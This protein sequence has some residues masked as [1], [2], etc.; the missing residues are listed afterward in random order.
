MCVKRELDELLDIVV[1]FICLAEVWLP[2]PLLLSRDEVVVG[3][4]YTTSF[5]RAF[6]ASCYTL[7]SL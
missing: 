1:L 5:A 2:P 7:N 3:L 4:V 6:S